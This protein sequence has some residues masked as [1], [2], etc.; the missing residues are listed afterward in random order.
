MRF[1]KLFFFH[2]KTYLFTWLIHNSFPIDGKVDFAKE[3]DKFRHIVFPAYLFQIS[4]Y[5]PLNTSEEGFVRWYYSVLA[6]F[7]LHRL[8]RYLTRV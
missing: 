3:F 2:I 6:Y 8:S 7:I 1:F 5:L 4:N